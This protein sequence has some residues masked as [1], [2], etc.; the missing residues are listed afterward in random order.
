MT[1]IYPRG[2]GPVSIA[3]IEPEPLSYDMRALASHF[4]SPRAFCL[5]FA[6]SRLGLARQPSRDGSEE[7]ARDAFL[8]E[9]IDASERPPFHL[10]SA[11]APNALTNKALCTSGICAVYIAVTI[12]VNSV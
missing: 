9:M 1:Y 7:G 5:F 3:S 8:H 11:A 6:P 10:R 4:S 12:V 2:A